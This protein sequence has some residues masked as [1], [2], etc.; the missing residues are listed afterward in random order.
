M[1]A[2]RHDLDGLSAHEER[3]LAA[4]ARLRADGDR[5]H[6]RALGRLA[7]LNTRQ[8]RRALGQLER[9]GLIELEWEGKDRGI[10]QRVTVRNH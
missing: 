2:T 10:G 9:R 1:T 5:L 8:V 3:V 7:N 4:L 6:V